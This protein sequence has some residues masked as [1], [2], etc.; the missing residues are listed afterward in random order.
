MKKAQQEI[1][2]FVLIVVLVVVASFIFLVFSLR[3]RDVRT[4]SVEVSTLLNALLMQTTDCVVN[5]PLPEN[6]RG[7]IRESY[8]GKS[9]AHTGGPARTYLKDQ[10]KELMD[11]VMKIENRFEGYR[12]TIGQRD[13]DGTII[14][15]TAIIISE[16]SN[17]A[18]KQV[19]GAS[20]NI[21]EELSIELLVCLVDLS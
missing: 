5:Q 9:C 8:S 16:E 20:Q 3:N 18:G 6:I 11:D 19:V 15:E 17:C 13:S 10:L 4:D 7:L 21:P 2:G 1:A 14:G 12:I